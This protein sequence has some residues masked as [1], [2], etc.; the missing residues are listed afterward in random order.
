MR[1]YWVWADL[2]FLANKPFA[3]SRIL[4]YDSIMFHTLK[5]GYDEH[6]NSPA[7]KRRGPNY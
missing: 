2:I 6:E 5:L 1:A 4:P 7:M 3:K